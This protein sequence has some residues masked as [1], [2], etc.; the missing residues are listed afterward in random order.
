MDYE[1]NYEATAVNA[2]SNLENLKAIH[3]DYCARLLQLAAVN[4]DSN[5][6][7]LKAIHN[8]QEYRGWIARVMFSNGSFFVNAK[9]A[10]TYKLTETGYE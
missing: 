6:E 8:P 7:N 9:N 3:N 10:I 2:D 1:A 5:L 4:A